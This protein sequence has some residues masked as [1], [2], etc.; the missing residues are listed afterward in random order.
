[1]EDEYFNL[2]YDPNEVGLDT[3]VRERVYNIISEY[4]LGTPWPTYSER[5]DMDLFWINL[6]KSI[7]ENEQKDLV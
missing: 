5:V 3:C 7:L 4:F 6:D 2:D 1:M